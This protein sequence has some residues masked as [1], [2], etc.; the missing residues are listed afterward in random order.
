MA[1]TA[2][3]FKSRFQEQP[4]DSIIW[5]PDSVAKPRYV[6]VESIRLEKRGLTPQTAE[7]L[8]KRTLKIRQA[9]MWKLG[10]MHKHSIASKLH[11][12]GMEDVALKLDSC[13]TYYTIAVCGDCGSVRKFPNRCDLFCCP[14]CAHALSVERVRQIQWWTNLISQPKHVTLTVKNIPVLTSGHV[15]EFRSWFTKLRRR[16]FASNWV[17]GFYRMEVTNEGHGWHLHLHALVDAKWIDKAELSRQW[18]QITNQQGMIVD[19]RD[20]RGTE[21]LHEVTKYVAK[22][23]QVAAWEPDKIAMYIRAFQG[24]RTFGV[25]GKLYSMRTEFAEWIALLKDL[26]PR[27]QCGSCNVSYYSEFEWETKDLV[28]DYYVR[29]PRPRP[30][31]D[32]PE[33]LP[34]ERSWPD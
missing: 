26:R 5:N 19:V 13:H 17:G 27:C 3:Q 33:L 30:Y 21:Y 2:T 16:K 32:Q 1:A 12:V 28:P 4:P 24:I 34:D 8:Q 29:P 11:A 25:F 10:T 22:G 20:C 15:Q 23:S 9:E 6:G 31:Q 18:A 7:V 14:E